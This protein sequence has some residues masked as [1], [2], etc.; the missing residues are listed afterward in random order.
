[1]T[2]LHGRRR[3]PGQRCT[4][5]EVQ[6]AAVVHN[7][8]ERHPS[9]YND[10]LKV[11]EL[12][13]VIEADGWKPVRTTGSHRHFKHPSK[14]TVVTVPREAGR[15]P[16]HRNSQGGPFW[17]ANN[18]SAYV[19]DLPGCITT[20]ATLDETKANI[21]EAIKGHLQTLKE[22]GDPLPIPSSLAGEVEVTTA[23]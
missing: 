23:V 20:G 8:R 15:R 12:V 13:R 19:P 14:P 21:R 3:G 9:G 4:I 7:S 2:R 18:W 6:S 17:A 22:F 5:E 11:R 1:M 10:E 16:C